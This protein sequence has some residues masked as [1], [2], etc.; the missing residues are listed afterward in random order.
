MRS[1]LAE[2]GPGLKRVCAFTLIE[3]LVVIAI[4]AI[5]AGMLLPALSRAKTKAHG[6]QCVNNIKQIGLAH[7]MYVNDTG[8]TMPYVGP[9]D[10]YDLWMKKLVQGYAFVNKVR[11]CPV[12]ADQ[13]PWVQRSSLLSGFG[14][15]D[16]AW[17][18]IYGTTNYQGSY[19][20]NGWFYTGQRDP[21]KEFGS[22]A[23]IR[24]PARTPVFGDS[25]WV[26]A[27]PA[28]TDAPARNLFEGGNSTSMQRFC[29]ARHGGR[30]AKAAP[31]FVG[32][33]QP[34]PGGITVNFA[35]GHAEPV[36]L[37][38]LWTLNW[39]KNYV[40]PARRPN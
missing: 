28:A 9:G 20:L 11:V 5:L 25:I 34:L 24:Q 2:S 3:L 1:Q 32:A 36:K 10:T 6:I 40:V 35:D 7:F 17:H 31:R 8:K 15:V 23:G 16:Q 30:H 22:E 12:A 13:I 27:W 33:G 26:D 29:I 37:E 39:H 19:A 18:W 38:N 21:N 14:M 4:I